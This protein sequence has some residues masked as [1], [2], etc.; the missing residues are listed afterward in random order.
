MATDVAF[1]LGVVALLG[2]RVPASVKVLVLTLAIVD[3]I[4][5]IV[6]IAVFYTDDLRPQLLLVAVGLALVVASDAPGPRD[7]RPLL[8]GGGS[9]IVV[10][11]LRVRG[12]RH[13]RRRRSGTAHA[14]AADAD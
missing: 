14:G 4:G 13:D 12:P 9:R 1:A 11:R 8:V 3:D 6:V 5:A 10:R 2:R 7:A